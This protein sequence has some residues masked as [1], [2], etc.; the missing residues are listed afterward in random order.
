M[1]IFAGMIV[2]L[3]PVARVR[4]WRIVAAQP[5][6]N[7]KIAMTAVLTSTL[8]AF[9]FNSFLW[10]PGFWM[11]FA[12]VNMAPIIFREDEPAASLAPD[13]VTDGA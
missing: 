2:S 1:V 10:Y 6:R 12:L 11:V 4:R 5:A 7:M 8:V 13:E 3:F 9:L